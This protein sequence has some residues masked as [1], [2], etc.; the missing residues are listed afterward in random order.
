[1]PRVEN[2]I[3]GNMSEIIGLS[4]DNCSSYLG[5]RHEKRCSN[6]SKETG[7]G[8]RGQSMDC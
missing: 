6:G 1:M 8:E 5:Y 3:L 7:G 2:S 4:W